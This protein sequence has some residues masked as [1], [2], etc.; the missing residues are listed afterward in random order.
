MQYNN[1]SFNAGAF[2]T[3]QGSVW[4]VRVMW[5]FLCLNSGDYEG[6]FRAGKPEKTF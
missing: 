4:I 3:F 5:K 6:S 1:S 2:I